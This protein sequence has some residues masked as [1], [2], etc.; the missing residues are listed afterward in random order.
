M[1]FHYVLFLIGFLVR[2]SR[3]RGL[4]IINL[5]DPR[6][7]TYKIKIA[8]QIVMGLACFGMVY[9]TDVGPDGRKEFEPLALVYIFFGFLWALSVY[10]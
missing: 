6:P 4:G 5:N 1:N 2:F 3:H 10:L 8:L 7:R 9:D